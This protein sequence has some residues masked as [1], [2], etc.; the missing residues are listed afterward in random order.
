[1]GIGSDGG[2]SRSVHAASVHSGVQSPCGSSTHLSESLGKPRGF[3]L[4]LLSL[5]IQEEFTD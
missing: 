2:R 4:M 1:M 3:F 5:I